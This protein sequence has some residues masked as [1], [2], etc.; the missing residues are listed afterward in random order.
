MDMKHLSNN[1]ILQ[2]HDFLQFPKLDND[3]AT[4]LT[5]SEVE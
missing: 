3:K 1:C 4:A 2:K 5:V